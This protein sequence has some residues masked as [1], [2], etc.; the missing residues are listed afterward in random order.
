M[1]CNVSNVGKACSS[2]ACAVILQDCLTRHAVIVLAKPC[3]SNPF[4]K[5]KNEAR[6]DNDDECDS[7]EEEGS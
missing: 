2:H 3:A 6:H 5:H 7:T 1:P 4:T